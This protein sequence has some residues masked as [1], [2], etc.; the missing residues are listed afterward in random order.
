MA[1]RRRTGSFSPN[2]SLRLR[3]SKV[4]M[5]LD[6]V[7]S[8]SGHRQDH[9]NQIFHFLPPTGS[10]FCYAYHGFLQ[11]QP[12]PSLDDLHRSQAFFVVVRHVIDAGALKL[13]RQ[14]ASALRRRCISSTETFS[15]CVEIVHVLPNGSRTRP[16]REPKNISVMGLNTLAPASTARA[17]TAS[18]SATKI[19]ASKVCSGHPSIDSPK[20]TRESPNFSSQ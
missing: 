5:L 18:E 20:F 12:I 15:L 2:T 8:V 14:A 9:T 10:F 7:F 11:E 13:V 1:A 4:D 6:I 19:W 16:S 17:K 3:S